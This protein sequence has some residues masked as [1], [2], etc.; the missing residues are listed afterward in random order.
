MFLKTAVSLFLMV[1]GLLI[2]NVMSLIWMLI[3]QVSAL[4]GLVF[5]GSLFWNGRKKE[6][7]YD[8]D[9]DDRHP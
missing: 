2:F 8:I 7:E 3:V 6:P 1:V 5:L 9:P 4:I